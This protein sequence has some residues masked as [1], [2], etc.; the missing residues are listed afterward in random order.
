[1]LGT[2]AAPETSPPDRLTVSKH[3]EIAR[4]FSASWPVRLQDS[5]SNVDSPLI[6][7]Q[8]LSLRPL[9]FFSTSP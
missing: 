7:T 9:R 4:R 2:S 6:E 1:M 3:E 5:E 8:I